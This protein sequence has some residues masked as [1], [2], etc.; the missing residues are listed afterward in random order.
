MSTAI[1]HVGTPDAIKG[2]RYLFATRTPIFW[3]IALT[4]GITVMAPT[5][6][7]I[8]KET[9]EVTGQRFTT[10]RGLV[11]F[12]RSMLGAARNAA[13][14]SLRE[15]RDGVLTLDQAQDRMA[16]TFLRPLFNWKVREAFFEVEQERRITAI[17]NIVA[18]AYAF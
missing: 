8:Y 13:I 15:V 17:Q 2:R 12:Y 16:D 3:A 9:L 11:R 6:L 4:F 1:A 10:A 18:R 5:A 7:R 14:V